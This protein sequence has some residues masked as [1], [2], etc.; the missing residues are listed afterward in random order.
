[1]EDKILQL[2]DVVQKAASNTAFIHHKWFVKYHLDIVERIALELC[3]IYKKADKNLVTMLVWLHD[4]GK[5]IDFD[6]QHTTTL[7]ETPKVLSSLGFKNELIEKVI[8]YIEIIDKK[9]NLEKDSVPI[10]IKI[11]SSADGAAHLVGPFFKL[12]WYENAEK[13]FEELMNENKGKATKD[14]NKKIVLPEV[15]KAFEE[16]HLHLLEQSGV[17]PEQFINLKQN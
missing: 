14:W 16:R 3:D 1:M 2:K 13:D 11:V 5:I 10:E 9:E 12:F 4:Y 7:E 15:K 8:K 17:F 6:N